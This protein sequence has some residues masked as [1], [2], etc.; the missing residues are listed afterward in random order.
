MFLFAVAIRLLL[1]AP[2]V[3]TASLSTGSGQQAPLWIPTVDAGLVLTLVC[4]PD[5][6]HENPGQADAYC[7]IC[8]ADS[9]CHRYSLARGSCVNPGQADAYCKSCDTD[10][11]CRVGVRCA[12]LVK[13]FGIQSCLL[14]EIADVLDIE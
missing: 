10:A 7:T 4:P 2:M 9:E 3:R 8:R 6:Y 13:A 1:L 14:A 5:Y 12:N 11:D